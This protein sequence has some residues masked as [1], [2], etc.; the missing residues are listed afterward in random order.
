MPQKQTKSKR[1]LRRRLTDK[2]R[3]FLINRAQGM[4]LEKAAIAAGYSENSARQAGNRAMDR[5]AEKAPELFARHGLDDDSYVDKCILPLL[6]ATELKVFNHNGK[7]IYSKPLP[8]LGIRA[9]MVELIAELKGMRVKEQETP[10][11]PIRVVVLDPAHR[12]PQPPLPPAPTP[13]LDLLGVPK[14]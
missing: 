5:I 6:N 2:E 11:T 14:P 4:T 10:R 13:T 1:K 12:P 8:A 3:K 9:R 7:L